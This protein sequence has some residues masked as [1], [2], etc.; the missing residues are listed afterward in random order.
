MPFDFAHTLREANARGQREFSELV[1]PLWGRALS[2]I[3]FDQRYV[4]A[5]GASLWDADGR[6]YLDLIAG[7]ATCNIGRNHPALVKALTDALASGHPSMVQFERPS[8][9]GLLAEELVKRVGRG[10]SRVFF[11]NSGTEGI[12]T[13]I[14]FARCATGRTAVMGTRGGFHG[15]TTGSLSI[16]GCESFREGFGE[17]HEGFSCIPFND[18]EAL[19]RALAARTVAAFV[20]EPIQGK[21]V[22]IPDG[23]YLAEA[24]RICRL[25]GTLFVVDEVQTGVGR[26]GAFLAIDHE[27]AVEPD[28]LVLS[29]ALSGGHVP[30][31]AV[32]CRRQVWERVFSRLDRAIV[33]SSTFHMGTLAMV[34]GLATLAIYDEERLAER[35]LA[36]GARLADGIRQ[37]AAR[38]ELIAGVRQRGLMIGIEFGKPTSLAL[39]ASWRT[40]HAIDANLFAQSITMP[41]IDDHAILTQVAGHGLDVLKLTPPLVLNE[42]QETRFLA[43]FGATMD[44]LHRGGGPAWDVLKRIA[45]NALGVTGRGSATAPADSLGASAPAPA[46]RDV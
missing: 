1:N 8:L 18:L 36:S 4:R 24:S 15:L 32:I 19:E 31:G 46:S 37:I 6:E 44:R 43:A 28:I 39:R 5:A 27:G 41:M 12:E 17:F 34:A 14:K 26:T 45:S 2:L 33:H 7:Y 9:A 40:V 13:A 3:G 23:G 11:T 42:A 20:C 25:H 29:K 30:V 22:N 38:G 16:N 21:G 35:A 10:L